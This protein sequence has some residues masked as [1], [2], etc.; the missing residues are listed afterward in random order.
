MKCAVFADVHS[1]YDA[2]KV[3]LA[4]IEGEKPDAIYCL[5]DIVGYGAEPSVCIQ[6]VRALNCPTVAGNHDHAVAGRLNTEF[7]HAD[8]V[9]GIWWTRNRIS[10]EEQ[11]FL[12]NLELMSDLPAGMIVHSTPADPSSFNYIFSLPEAM[13]A[14]DAMPRDVCFIGHSHMPVTFWIGDDIHVDNAPRVVLGKAEK[15]IINVGSVGQPRDRNPR[16]AY[17]LYDTDLKR[18]EI[19][20]LE[21]DWEAAAQKILAAGLPGANAYRL[22]LGA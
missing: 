16:A 4:D 10:P 15:A 19:R 18:L 9:E 14:F 13:Q 2:L 7:F 5:G 8:A 21:Y 11:Q 22:A 17:A 20:R 12:R 3:V 6:A 1:N